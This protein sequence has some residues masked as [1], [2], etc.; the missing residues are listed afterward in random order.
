MSSGPMSPA[1]SLE[2]EDLIDEL[3]AESND[4][5][6]RAIAEAE[7]DSLLANR[8]AVQL[9]RKRAIDLYTRGKLSE[10]EFDAI[11]ADVERERNDPQ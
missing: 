7:R 2:P 11:A 1:S 10:I 4:I 8:S 3:L 9:R 5:E 6:S